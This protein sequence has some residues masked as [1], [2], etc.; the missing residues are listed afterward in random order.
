MNNSKAVTALL[1][2][3]VTMVLKFNTFFV[4]C[5]AINR[6]SKF[7]FFPNETTHLLKFNSIFSGF[8]ERYS[9]ACEFIQIP[10]F[11]SFMIVAEEL[12]VLLIGTIMQ[13]SCYFKLSMVSIYHIK[14]FHHLTQPR[15]YI[16][17]H[18]Y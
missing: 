8:K 7:Y 1:F 15:S 17:L 14:I 4:L 5:G 12:L 16:H 6:K 10:T 3:Q 9:K 18:G 13:S 2:H 11:S